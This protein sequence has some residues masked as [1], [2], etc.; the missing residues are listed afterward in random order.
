[1]EEFSISNTLSKD[2]IFEELSM[3]SATMEDAES[4][5]GQGAGV[6]AISNEKIRKGD[7]ILGTY[8]VISDAIH[9]GMGSVWRVHHKSWNADLAMKRPQPKFFAEGGDQGMRALDQSGPASEYRQL[10]LCSRYRRRSFDL[11]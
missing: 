2:S 7:E 1:M 9:G 10:L 4:R 6:D 11:L 5:F 3:F 8:E